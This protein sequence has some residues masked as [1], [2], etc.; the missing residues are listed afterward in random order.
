MVDDPFCTSY[1][2]SICGAAKY[3]IRSFYS[4]TKKK[5]VVVPFR[6][7]TPDGLKSPNIIFVEP[8]EL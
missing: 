2:R 1:L 3:Q 8:K 5:K 4:Y 6:G 7:L